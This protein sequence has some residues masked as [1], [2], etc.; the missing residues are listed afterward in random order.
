MLLLAQY[1]EESGIGLGKIF[2][3]VKINA[4]D[5]SNV[6]EKIAKTSLG[7]VLDGDRL[8]VE[9]LSKAIGSSDSIILDYAQTLKDTDGN[10]DLTT[11]STEGLS[12][13]LE[14]SGN[15]F[16]FA[17]IKATLLNT[18]LN[19]GIFLV[20]SVA[21]QGIAK[22]L[23]N[24]IHRVEKARERTDELF[25]EFKQ[26]N[27]TLADHRKTVSELTDRYDELSKGVN[28]SNNDNL[29]LSTD[30]YEE[31]LDINEQ[32]ANS[33]PELAKG[34]DE[35]GNSILT[36]GTK[37]ITAKEQLEELLQTEQDL[38]N[39][40]IAQGLED[41]F[42][43]VYTYVEDANEATEKLNGTINDSN[44][45]MSKLQ[46]IAENGIKLTGENNQFIFGGDISNQAELDYMNSLTASINEFWESLDGSRRVE[47]GVN[48]S[49]LFTQESD[50]TGSFEIYANLY[51]LTP[52]EL[53]TLE[54]IIQD[55]VG[56]AS[57]A[58]LDSISDQSQELQEQVQKGENAWRD[59][60]PNLVSGMKSKQTFKNLDSDLQ[61][62]AVQL[63]EGLDYSYAS[64]MK[65]Y[66]PD[67]YAYIRDKFIVPMSNLDD[68][69]KQKLQ[70]SFEDLLKLDAD[71]LAQSNQSEIERFITTIATLLEKD[72]LEIRVALGF[73]IED[74]QNRYNE[75]LKQAK[76]KFG[77]YGHDDKGFEINNS[78]G[79]Q[80][81]NFWNENVVTEEDW[82]LWQKV[83]DGI[84]DATEAMNAY[85]EAK[86][87]ANAVSV[88][89]TGISPI[90][91]SQTIDQLN[92]QLKPA[93]DSLKSAYQDI[94]TDDGFTL[95]NVDTSM[96]SSIKSTIYEL[97]N[98]EDVDINI[99]YSSFENLAKVL[100]D[101]SSE[102]WQVQEA[103]DEFATTIVNSLNPA[104]SQCD[105]ESYKL[106]QTLLE[107]MGIVNAEE[108]LLSQ[109]GYSYEEYA[110][111]KE[112]AANAGI[113]LNNS[114]DGVATALQEEG[115]MATQDAQQIMNYML[116]KMSAS[117]AT[118]D[119]SS[120]IGQLAEEYDWL[121][122]LINQWGL[123]YSVSQ[124]G[125]GNTKGSKNLGAGNYTPVQ[126]EEKVK[127]KIDAKFDGSKL[128]SAAKSA[129]K[130]AGK[131]LKDALKEELSDLESVISGITGR[132]DD[133][134][135]SINEQKS[136]ALDAISEEKEK[137]EEA[138][139]SAVAA[140]EEERQK[141]LD[142][143]EAQRKQIEQSIKEK[144]KVVDQINDEIKAIQDANEELK[145]E[146]DLQKAQYELERMQ[147]Q[148]TK[149][150]NYMPDIIVI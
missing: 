99:D 113:D 60:I 121:A 72:P 90:S 140:L 9:K 62:I 109:L 87:N 120:T 21:I 119:V 48:P 14:K 106:L 6:I 127:V 128:N 131:S 69:D 4:E 98:M 70:S 46:D 85:T 75:A 112:S 78:V 132:I 149:L 65:E 104:I 130:S 142:V 77:G 29:S 143:I 114:I 111:A 35:N 50:D 101:T 44:E 54:N 49:D 118:I 63:V 39:F 93:F 33:F 2:D 115:L 15:M 73:D 38:N 31:F 71:N 129:G 19:A 59:F 23:D 47:L 81:D 136:A 22:A 42:Q 138:K 95:E 57:G 7:D 91:I 135:S 32:L 80:I 55:N 36:L 74:V 1:T 18:A 146:I 26:M 83:T 105:G 43:G 68:S 25:D 147:N 40:R 12:A 108:V 116:A 102:S 37:G 17:A 125:H 76:R 86:K 30:E 34:I 28:L 117:G 24:Y 123:Y 139:E 79:D 133:Q 58:L 5:Y 92:T 64:A 82:V 137:L 110:N 126:T 3:R 53:T 148:R 67:P 84:D 66:D 122:E 150:V 144:Q 27:D 103:F 11:A 107:S 89:E 13:Y 100:T 124:K 10:I 61:D 45:A 41:A 94:F 145:R 20:A 51:N 88:D 52:D 96:L 16:N 134:I 141:R 56:D 8:S 97:N